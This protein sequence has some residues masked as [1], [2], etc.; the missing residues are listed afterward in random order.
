[1]ILKLNC[2]GWGFYR[3]RNFN[4]RTFQKEETGRK[5]REKGHVGPSVMAKLRCRACRET[6]VKEVSKVWSGLTHRGFERSLL[7]VCARF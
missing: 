1:M 6:C 7:P 5:D 2:K 3:W 4:K